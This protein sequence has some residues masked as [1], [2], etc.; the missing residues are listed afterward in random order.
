QRRPTT[1]RGRHLTG[2]TGGDPGVGPGTA[3]H[4][5]ARYGRHL[6]VV[7]GSVLSTGR[8]RAKTLL[9][10]LVLG[11]EQ[12][13]GARDLIDAASTARLPNPRTP[14]TVTRS[15]PVRHSQPSGSSRLSAAR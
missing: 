8:C 15:A 13:A 11:P 10:A 5:P 2:R 3:R 1:R 4:P 14:R 6:P 9:L 12:S 7:R